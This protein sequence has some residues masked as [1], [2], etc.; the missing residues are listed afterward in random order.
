MMKK[1]KAERPLKPSQ[2]KSISDFSSSFGTSSDFKSKAKRRKI[3]RIIIFAICIIALVYIGFFITDVL[4]RI[5][6]IPTDTSTTT[7]HISPEATL[8]WILSLSIHG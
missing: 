4:I 6:E 3:A 1:K 2:R 5:S 7:A 8:S